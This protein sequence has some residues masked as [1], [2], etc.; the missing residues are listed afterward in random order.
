MSVD[1]SDACSAVEGG[2][3]VEV[4]AVPGA[5]RS[6]VVGLHDGALRVRIDAPAE[7]GKANRAIARLLHE[8]TGVAA[9]LVQGPVS[10]RKRF[11]LH[12]ASVDQI[13]RAVRDH[14][15]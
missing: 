10:R 9:E 11:F 13:A 5:S 4:W 7:G 1:I 2:V 6:V 3:I 8:I 12:G 15:Q 14:M